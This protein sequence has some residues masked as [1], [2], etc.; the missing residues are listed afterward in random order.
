[1]FRFASS[2]SAPPL[3]IA[4]SLVM[5]ATACDSDSRPGGSRAV[6]LMHRCSVVTEPIE[7]ED[8]DSAGVSAAEVLAHAA[9]RSVGWIEPVHGEPEVVEIRFA[10]HTGALRKQVR[11]AAGHWPCDPEALFADGTLRIVSE[12]RLLDESLAVTV[13]AVRDQGVGMNYFLDVRHGIAVSELEGSLTPSDFLDEPGFALT[14]LELSG[15]FK[16]GAFVGLLSAYAEKHTGQLS[17]GLQFD[18]LTL[19]T[20]PVE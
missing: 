18:I 15:S 6:D 12:H 5:T 11:N 9:P 10:P 4:L 2:A 13:E 19:W 8:P 16:D 17:E 14:G 1:M 3:V 20:E 7:L